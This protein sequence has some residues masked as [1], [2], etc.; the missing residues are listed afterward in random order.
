VAAFETDPTP[1]NNSKTE[2][3]LVRLP[4]PADADLAIT[5]TVGPRASGQGFTYTLT[6]TNHGPA[7]ATRV[8]LTND[9]PR[10]LDQITASQ[11]HCS[12]TDPMLCALGELTSGAGATV[13]VD[14]IRT[15][16]TRTP[17]LTGPRLT[18]TSMTP[19]RRTTSP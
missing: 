18:G 12:V 14:V 8:Q 10:G 7:T 1:A 2:T 19:I 11:G 16:E 15:G 17:S 4:D 3:T 9:L 13:T 5:A 6:V